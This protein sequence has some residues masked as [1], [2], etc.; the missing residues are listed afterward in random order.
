MT[1]PPRLGL[2]RARG[3]AELAFGL[4]VIAV[5][6]IA[7]DAAAVAARVRD[8]VAVVV[9]LRRSDDEGPACLETPQQ[10]Y[11]VGHLLPI[12]QTELGRALG[13]AGA[14]LIEVVLGHKGDGRV[15]GALPVLQHQLDAPR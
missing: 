9:V 4:H 1:A 12:H 11:I 3:A 15:A 14:L 5:H 13:A 7:H 6:V 8:G 2:A 10:R